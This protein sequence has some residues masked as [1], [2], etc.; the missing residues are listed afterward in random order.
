MEE[1]GLT[2][3]RMEAPVEEGQETENPVA[4]YVYG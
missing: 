1:I 2:H 4:L 3:R